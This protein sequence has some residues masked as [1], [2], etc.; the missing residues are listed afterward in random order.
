MFLL[1]SFFFSLTSEKVLFSA[2]A[3]Y[4]LGILFFWGI[5]STNGYGDIVW[6]VMMCIG[7][8]LCLVVR[9]LS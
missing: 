2:L 4:A 6:S 9:R 3:V 7:E 8:G 1:F 5:S